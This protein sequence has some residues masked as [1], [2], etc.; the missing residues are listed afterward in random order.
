VGDVTIAAA[1]NRI[2]EHHEMEQKES[3]LLS[4][5]GF[6]I[7]I[8]K[9]ELSG[10]GESTSTGAAAS[11][12][13]AI[14]GDVVIRSGGHYTQTG[15][16]VLAPAGDIAIAAR[17]I[18]IT[19]A[20][21]RASSRS[22]QRF[23]Q[24]GIT[25][26]LSNPVIGALQTAGA[27]AEAAGNTGDTRMQALAAG[28][29][30]LSAK[31][32]ID[33]VRAGQGATIGGKEGQIRTG[34]T[35][36]DGTPETRDA[37]ALEKAGGLNVSVSV[38][39]ASSESHSWQSSD[40][41]RGSNVAA[42]G[43]VTLVASGAGQ[44]SNLTVQGSN[45]VAGS[46]ITLYADNQIN[47]LA[48]QETA[49]QHSSSK[50]ASGSL[51]VSFGTSGF[52]VTA[53]ASSGRDHAGG[54]SLGYSNTHVAAGRT[55]TLQSGGDT[56][57]RG[58]VASA[59]QITA[60][61][62]GNLAIESLQDESSYDAKQES[63]G[64]S[65][66]VGAG[67]VSGSVSAS[68]GNTRSNY[69]SV[70]EQSALRAGD[71]GF[72]VTVLGHTD[73]TGGAITS[74]QAA[75]DEKK[76]HFTS[77][78]LSMNDLQNHADYDANAVGVSLGT[79]VNLTGQFQ[80][81][82]SGAGVG[83]ASG[84]AGS[85]TRSAISGIA[86]DREAR[87]GQAEA[88][89]GPIFDAERV[90]K[91]IN[92]QVIITQT[93]GAQAG[94]AVKDYAQ[95]ERAD[96]YEKLGKATS[97]EDKTALE[98]RIKDVNMQERALNILVG[99]LTGQAGSVVTKEALSTAAEQMRDLMIED[100]KRFEGVIDAYG[101]TLDN[102]S[103]Q[104]A[105]VR[106]DG[107][108]IGGT[109]VDLDLLCGADNSRCAVQKDENQNPILD[110]NGRMQFALRDGMVQFVGPENQEVPM[111]LSE[112][113]NNTPEGQRLLGPTGGIQG[114]KG[115]LFGIPYELGSWQ[116]R[117]VEA[118]AGTHDEIG[119]KTSGLY[120]AQGNIKREMSD[121]ERRVYNIWSAVAI[122]P[123]TPFAASEFLSPEVWAV[124][125]IFLKAAR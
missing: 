57:L 54:D 121:V 45:V 83:S 29:T 77:A 84:Q 36:P 47:L 75:I 52:G 35:N 79:A 76:N 31:G 89:I 15:S 103:G 38:G 74:T 90:H 41:A 50:G 72:D 26:A 61:V 86:G 16:D 63:M 88:G 85:T 44:A 97:D 95:S 68:T 17:Q 12:V 53:A 93:F 125:S 71:A 22:E 81:S 123:A 59:D 40:N 69:Q 9:R 120:D 42:G 51:G 46:D 94:K 66:T 2:T 49:S 111:T 70:A 55:L 64:G 67:F 116:D 4:G 30:A 124:M 62:S 25:L 108:R 14:A 65:L 11:T 104:S 13:G 113:V 87:T 8:G 23:R 7:T 99:A 118:F 112:F 78:G 73:L 33:A 5:G 21:E 110:A 105:G 109:R 58:A 20:R 119:G 39:S 18:D 98:R 6:G 102:I 117:L 101:N 32:A 1:E 56:T 114:F 43:S 3:G 115:T 28:A 60:R 107:Y 19:E 96:L 82:G 24:S 100:S 80:P 91:E 37:T 48:A 106:G 122:V 92:A 34:G 10:S 27:M